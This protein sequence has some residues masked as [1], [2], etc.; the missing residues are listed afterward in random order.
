VKVIQRMQRP[1]CLC[2]NGRR[3]L[4][5]ASQYVEVR[6]AASPPTIESVGELSDVEQVTCRSASY[7]LRTRFPGYV[8]V[9]LATMADRTG[10]KI[11][12]LRT[13]EPSLEDLFLH[14]TGGGDSGGRKENE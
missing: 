10:W 1:K 2:L 13:P 12:D 4:V 11:V 14:F 7:R 6:F 8:V 3:Q 9:A 5:Q